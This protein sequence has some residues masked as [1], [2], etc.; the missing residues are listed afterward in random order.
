MKLYELPRNTKFVLNGETFMLH[1]IDG[2]YSYCTLVPVVYDP[3]AEPEVYHFAA[4]T[5]VELAT[6][7]NSK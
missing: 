2:M 6:Q 3:R 4:W 7:N 1:S 5:D